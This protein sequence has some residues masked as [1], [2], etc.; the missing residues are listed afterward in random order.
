LQ[1]LRQ[2]SSFPQW[3]DVDGDIALSTPSLNKYVYQDYRIPSYERKTTEKKEIDRNK[4]YESD[5]MSFSSKVGL[6]TNM[7]TSLFGMLSLYEENSLEYKTIINRLKI[8]NALQQMLID[9]AKGIRIHPFPSWWMNKLSEEDK[10]NL[11]PK[12]LNYMKIEN[13]VSPLLYEIC[14]PNHSRKG[15][16]QTPG[17]I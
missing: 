2:F 1:Y 7:A 17:N 12:K 15:V 10:E 4:L 3:A 6:L 13:T 9:S 8:S 14:L 5:I 16:P 11:T